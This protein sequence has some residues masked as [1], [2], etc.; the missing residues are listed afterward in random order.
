MKS[1]R[2][3]FAYAGFLFLCG[4]VAFAIA[5]FEPR[6]M[7]SIIV[8]TATALVMLVC[9]FMSNAITRNRAVG[10]IGI[11]VGLALPLV[12]AALFAWRGWA[13][14]QGYQAGERGLYLPI[15]LAVMALGSVVAF[16]LILLTRPKPADRV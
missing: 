3:M 4:L 5:G 7:T 16:V 8:G 13:A 9:G 10:M 14:W 15:T 1:P 11:H 12:F 6:A 2:I